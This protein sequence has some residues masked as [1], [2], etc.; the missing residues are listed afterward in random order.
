MS[1]SVSRHVRRRQCHQLV[2]PDARLSALSTQPRRIRC[3]LRH[4]AQPIA[5]GTPTIFDDEAGVDYRKWGRSVCRFF[6]PDRR[7]SGFDGKPIN[8]NMET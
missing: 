4:R 6:K 3:E 8:G 5:R 7:L 2:H 1:E